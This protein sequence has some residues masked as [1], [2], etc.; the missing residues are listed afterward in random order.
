MPHPFRA[1][2]RSTR[3]K[4]T[5]EPEV[6]LALKRLHRKLGRAQQQTT[7]LTKDLLEKLIAVCDDDLIGLRNKVLLRLGY[8]TMRRHAELCAFEFSDIK[9]MPNARYAI[10]L[11]SS[12]TDQYG[13]G[14]L[15]PISD[16]LVEL[17]NDWKVKANLEHGKILRGFFKGKSIRDKLNPSSINNILKQLQAEA[18]INDMGELSGHSFRV[19]SA[20]DML[21]KGIPLER[22]M[23]RGGWKSEITAMRY[24]RSWQEEYWSQD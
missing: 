21:S 2:K 14:K 10:N 20:V 6:I 19:G 7:P 4:P 13:E 22:I 15:L 18:Q 17:I 23:L 5:Q 12:K 1:K 8:E 3:I 9:H 16:T 11:R 24:L